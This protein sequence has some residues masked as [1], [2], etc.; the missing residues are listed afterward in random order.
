[1]VLQIPRPLIDAM[2]D[3]ARRALPNECCGFLAGTQ[4]LASRLIPLSN[5][6]ASPTAYRAAPA[7]LF[8]AARSMHAAREE[9]VAIYH[10]HP[11]SAARPS[12]RDLAENFYEDTP[13]IIISLAGPEPDVRAFRLFPDRFEEIEWR[14]T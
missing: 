4:G 12:R 1:M 8:V 5:E 2:I 11:T 13:H 6:L 3:E 7:D 10:S 9:V 14:H